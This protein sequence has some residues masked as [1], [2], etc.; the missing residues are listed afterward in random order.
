MSKKE[1]AKKHTTI[2]VAAVLI[3]V[4]AFIGAYI[5]YNK[6]STET[7]SVGDAD[8][9]VKARADKQKPKDSLFTT[10]FSI[11]HIS[12]VVFYVDFLGIYDMDKTITVSD[13]Y[14]KKI[15]KTVDELMKGEMLKIDSKYYGYTYDS[16]GTC[17]RNLL[18]FHKVY[19]DKILG[20]RIRGG[21]IYHNGQQAKCLAMVNKDTLKSKDL[22]RILDFEINVYL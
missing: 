17:G 1:K 7:F 6:C 9:V 19:N 12:K 5:I 16:S 21:E 3:V 10:S 14:G 8:I 13:I 11:G 18:L 22:K 4:A 2:L 20:I 15:D